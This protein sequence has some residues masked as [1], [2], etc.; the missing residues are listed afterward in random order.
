MKEVKSVIRNAKAVVISRWCFRP[1]STTPG[2]QSEPGASSSS[3]AVG[4]SRFLY[5]VAQQVWSGTSGGCVPWGL[6][7]NADSRAPPQTH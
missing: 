3:L 5:A 2:E 7:R 1:S 6:A 4:R